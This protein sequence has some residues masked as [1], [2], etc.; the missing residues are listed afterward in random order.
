MTIKFIKSMQC[1]YIYKAEELLNLEQDPNIQRAKEDTYFGELQYFF[2]LDES[3]VIGFSVVDIM[4]DDLDPVKEAEIRKIYISKSYRG[5]KYGVGF[6][7]YIVKKLKEMGVESIQ[8]EWVD[9]SSENFWRTYSQNLSPEF[10]TL[11][12]KIRFYISG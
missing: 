10:N 12:N 4:E 6:V 1:K 8:I 7:D 9:K 5:K 11:N 2:V 3:K